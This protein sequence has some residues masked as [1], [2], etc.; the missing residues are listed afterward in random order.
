RLRRTAFA[1]VTVL[2]LFTSSSTLVVQRKGFSNKYSFIVD[3]F[4][5]SPKEVIAKRRG[6][7]TS[8]TPLNTM[9]IH[10]LLNYLSRSL[11]IIFNFYFFGFV[12]SSR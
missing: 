9:T 8:F 1:G 12:F 11:K 4:V 10:G 5:K 2:R 7:L 6:N 3:E